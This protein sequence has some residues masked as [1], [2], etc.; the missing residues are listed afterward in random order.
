MPVLG[1][2]FTMGNIFGLPLLIGTAVEFGLNVVLSYMD[3]HQHDGPLVA[4][5]TIMAVLVNGLTTIIGFGTMM[6]ADHRG[7]FGLGLFLTIGMITSLI[8]S[9]AVLPVL[10]RLIHPAAP[11]AAERPRIAAPAATPSR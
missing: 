5:S 9:L 1:L 11:A 3:D 6:V 10:L 8:A 4:R 7:I 2:K